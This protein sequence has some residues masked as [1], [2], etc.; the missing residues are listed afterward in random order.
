MFKI[1]FLNNPDFD[2]TFNPKS[3]NFNAELNVLYP[4]ENGMPPGGIPG[5]ILTKISIKDYDA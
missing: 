2:T 5:S 1:N 4:A 3:S